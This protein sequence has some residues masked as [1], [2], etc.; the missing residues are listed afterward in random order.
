M[1]SEALE[2]K[3]Q[4][5]KDW[6]ELNPDSRLIS[7]VGN[8]DTFWGVYDES[9][10]SENTDKGRVKQ[11][12][13]VPRITCFTEDADAFE[14]NST[15]IN[16]GGEDRLIFRITKDRTEETFQANLWLV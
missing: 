8:S 14:A 6:F 3:K 2:L 16:W 4:Q 10:L 5:A 9:Y 12:K 7:V 1:S 13:M 15:K 11:Q